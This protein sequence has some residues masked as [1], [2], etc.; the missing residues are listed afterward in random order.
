MTFYLLTCLDCWQGLDRPLRMPFGSA[1]ERGKWASEHTKGTGH[2]HW[3]V[4]EE[5]L[6]IS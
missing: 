4:W 3:R 1:A 5:T 2:D 6:D